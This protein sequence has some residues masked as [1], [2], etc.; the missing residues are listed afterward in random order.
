MY[1]LCSP[2]KFKFNTLNVT[3]YIITLWAQLIQK[4]LSDWL[5]QW[6]QV[7][8][9]L[10]D[11]TE[12]IVFEFIDTIAI[13]QR[14]NQ[15]SHVFNKLSKHCIYSTKK[16]TMCTWNKQNATTKDVKL[17]MF[18]NLQLGPARMQYMFWFKILLVNVIL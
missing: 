6:I 7:V 10:N 15:P 4:L 2:I 5:D 14:W 12:W 3:I 8:F 13:Q 11:Y 18:G 9:I 17:S 16:P 1:R